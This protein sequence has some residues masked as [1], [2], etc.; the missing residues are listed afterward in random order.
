[1]TTTSM[2]NKIKRFIPKSL[3]NLIKRILSFV[4]WDQWLNQSWS[5]EGEDLILRR[6]F[7]HQ[8]AGFYVDVGAHHPKRFSNTHLFYKRG[9]SGINIDAMPGSM[10]LFDNMRPRDLNLELGIDVNES[11]LDYYIFNEPALNG[12]SDSLSNE[13]HNASSN[14]R[15]E[16]IIKINVLPL[17]S[18]FNQHLPTDQ[19]I[20]FLSVD[21]EGFDLNVLQSNNWEIYRPKYVLVEFLRSSLHEIDESDLGR[22]MKASGYTLFAKCVNTVFFKDASRYE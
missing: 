9:W 12:F 7:E 11:K 20:D 10:K 22:F 3:R 14:Y 21:V 19:K 5:Q 16:K 18:I 6:I 17:S 2:I 15:I 13:R 8:T 1:M 4:Y